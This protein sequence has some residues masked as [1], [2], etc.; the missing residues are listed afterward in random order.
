A[1]SKCAWKKRTAD[2]FFRAPPFQ[3]QT[4]WSSEQHVQQHA[5]GSRSIP[6]RSKIPSN[7]GACIA[8][9]NCI[10]KVCACIF[11]DASS[12]FSTRKRG[13]MKQV[14]H[15]ARYSFRIDLDQILNTPDNG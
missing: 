15:C 9:A 14:Q 10:E 3:R 7:D 8:S 2:H 4:K 5:T 1:Q 6:R 11:T 12:R 13:E